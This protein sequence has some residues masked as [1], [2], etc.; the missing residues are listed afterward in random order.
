MNK[1]I[2]N[3]SVSVIAICMILIAIGV[4]IESSFWSYNKNVNK[5]YNTTQSQSLEECTFHGGVW[6]QPDDWESKCL[7]DQCVSSK[8]DIRHY[9]EKI[10]NYSDE[11]YYEDSK[12]NYIYELNRAEDRLQEC[13]DKCKEDMFKCKSK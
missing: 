9:Q 10:D 5:Y 1:Y 11:N 7:E 4:L 8:D 13:L 6:S 3:I 2:K 12:E